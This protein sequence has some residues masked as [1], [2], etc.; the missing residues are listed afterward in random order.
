[1]RG[2]PKQVIRDGAGRREADDQLTNVDLV[3]VT[4]GTVRRDI[5]QLR[6]VEFE[7]VILDE[8]Q[9][10]TSEQ[11]KMFLTRLGYNS[12]A[13]VNGDVTQVDLPQGKPSGLKEAQEVLAGIDGIKLF[14]FDQRDVVR[15][16]L[17]QKIVT[18][19]ERFEQKRERTES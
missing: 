2:L 19:Y 6:H 11:M 7:Y 9:N 18:A 17:V 13:V 16:P 1:M 8:A 15:H 14:T 5:D 12:K 4:Y 3:I 10:T